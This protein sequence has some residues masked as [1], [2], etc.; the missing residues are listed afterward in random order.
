MNTVLDSVTVQIHLC[1]F[2]TPLHLS[3]PLLTNPCHRFKLS[4]QDCLLFLHLPTHKLEFVGQT[5]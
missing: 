3:Y 5:L 1:N 4:Y 2:I